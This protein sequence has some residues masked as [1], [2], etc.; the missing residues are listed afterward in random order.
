MLDRFTGMQVFVRVA[1]LGGFSQ[2][3]RAL[4]ISQTMVTKHIAALEQRLGSRLFHRS[5][6]RLTLTEG[7]RQFLQACERILND[8]ETA[9]A[10]AA[11]HVAEPRGTLRV[12]VPLTFGVRQI[13]PALAEYS[14]LYPEVTIDLG[15]TDR[16]VD[17]IAEEWDLAIRIGDS[18]DSQLVIRRLARCDMVLCAAPAYLARHGTPRTVAHLASHNC[19]A[20]TLSASIAVDRWPFGRNGEKTT[21]IAGT[22]RANN[23]DAVRAAAVAGLG[24]IY[25]PIF[26]V[27]D[28][29]I[30]GRL[31]AIALDQPT[32]GLPGVYAVF[33][34][35]GE[36]P[37][38]VRTFVEF[39]ARRW[40]PEPPWQVETRSPN[41]C[42]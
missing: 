7:G 18:K 5:T 3:A 17:L 4:G 6:R 1:A 29:I 11:A 20:Y 12:N 13:A 19:L 34:S 15:L 25:Q 14:A 35:R 32:F 22:F 39:F 10:T 24:I 33:P 38:K 36:P 9:E 41:H 28:D 2:A 31:V 8:V 37:A 27:A 30:A 42:P 21:P 16:F 23:G 40:A 26:I